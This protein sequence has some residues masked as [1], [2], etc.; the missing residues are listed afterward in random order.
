MEL[1]PLTSDEKTNVP[2]YDSVNKAVL[3]G[4]KDD[5]KM[6][7]AFIHKSVGF[8]FKRINSE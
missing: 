8:F 3:I 1:V 6:N 7:T 4:M 5:F 2:L